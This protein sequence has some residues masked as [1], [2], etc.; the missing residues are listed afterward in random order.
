M[1][2]PGRLVQFLDKR[3]LSWFLAPYEQE[4][5]VG[6][7]FR[8]T[9]TVIFKLLGYIFGREFLDELAEFL[10][11]FRDLYDGFRERHEAVMSLFGRTDTVFTVVCAPN[12]PSVAVARYFLNELADR[13]M[14]CA[15]VLMNQMHPTMGQDINPEVILGD[16]ARSLSDD[17]STHTDSQLLARLGSNH[18][19]LLGLSKA[20]QSLC[21][22]LWPL[23]GEEKSM[24]QIPRLEGEV[25]D[26]SALGRV[27][28]NARQL[29]RS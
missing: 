28:E 8:G 4:R 20:E 9:S 14:A 12:E 25:H 13:Q 26:I 2:S 6:R 27:F 7:F 24:W 22:I 11:I 3:I 18:K 10:F 5:V 1:E 21:H 16:L 19:R 23:L 17:L 15:G 29:K